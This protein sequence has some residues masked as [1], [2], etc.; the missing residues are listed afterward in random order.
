MNLSRLWTIARLD[1]TQRIRTVSWYVLLG[2]FAL[3]LVGTTA[4][5]FLSTVDDPGRFAR[6][7]SV[8]ACLGLTPTRHRSGEVDR[9]GRI[10]KRGDPLLRTYLAQ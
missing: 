10:S 2:V 6:S 3:V 8:G 5:A 9:S 4:L 7:K 1:L